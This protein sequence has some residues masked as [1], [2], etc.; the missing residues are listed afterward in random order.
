MGAFA[1]MITILSENGAILKATVPWAVVYEN[2]DII[3][4]LKLQQC[5]QQISDINSVY[6]HVLSST[7]RKLT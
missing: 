7:P 1:A 2:G 4:L 3:L 6:V 5:H